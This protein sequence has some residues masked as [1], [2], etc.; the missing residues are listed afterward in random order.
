[1]CGIAGY[2]DLSRQSGEVQQSLLDAMQQA[3]IHRGPDGFG[4]WISADKKLGFAFRRLAIIDLSENA[5]QPMSDDEHLCTIM[6][7]GEIYNHQAI[8]EDLE[9]LGYRYNSHSDTETILY[10]FKEWGI[11]CLDKFEGMF[12]LALYDDRTREL[13]LVRDRIGIKPLYFSIQDGVLSFASEIKALWVLPWNKKELS[14]LALYHYLTFMVS[15]APYTIFEKVYKLPAGFYAK[16]DVEKNITFHEWYSPLKSISDQEKKAFY[17]EQFVLENIEILLDQATKKRM[18]SDVPFGAFLSGGIDSSLNVALMA[19]HVG[20]VKTFTVAFSDGP[21]HDELVWART[22]ASHFGTDHHEVIISEKEAFE[23]YEIMVH[24][25]DEPL[26]DCVCI[27]LYYVARL[28]KQHGVSVVQIGEGA[29]ELFFGYPLYARYKQLYDRWWQPYKKIVPQIVR[30]AGA[31]LINPFLKNHVIHK[32]MLNNWVYD[33]EFFWGGALAFTEY[34]KKV[35]FEGIHEAEDDPIIKSIMRKF[36][37][38]FDSFH[39]VDFHTK[40]LEQIDDAAD[41]CRKVMYL[42]LKQRI[43]ELLLMRADKMTMAASVEARVPFLDH[44]LVEFLLQ[45]P[46]SL[47]FKHGITKYLL[48][49]VARKYLPTEIVDRRKVGFGAPTIRWFEHGSYFPA[50]FER[51]AQHQ[52]ISFLKFCSS[53]SRQAVQKWVMQNMWIVKR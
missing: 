49:K 22:V 24:Y 48:K 11:A 42:E 38:D 28:A 34:E 20:Q 19:K 46:G 29:D 23:F 25:L 21:E 2:Y 52:S 4:T 51:L 16:I 12:A 17:D 39:V 15:P 33:R 8:R 41:F 9:K 53:P 50:Y 30:K 18:M 43:P 31:Y 47:I 26:A 32:E 14:S 35:F 37:Q 7:N 1:M 27:P 36:T 44:K 3:I 45:V 13:Y 6:F 10:A 40:R 5:A